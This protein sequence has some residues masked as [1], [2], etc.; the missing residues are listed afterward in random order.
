MNLE[1]QVEED[2]FVDARVEKQ[3][4]FCHA[5][6]VI[7][8][9]NAECRRK[10]D[11]FQQP[12]QGIRKLMLNNSVGGRNDTSKPQ[13]QQQKQQGAMYKTVPQNN[14]G[15]LQRQKKSIEGQYR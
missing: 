13:H 9:D 10:R 7:G 6:R 2:F 1:K 14:M 4:K 8:H 3:P 15:K 5:C 11:R 12:S